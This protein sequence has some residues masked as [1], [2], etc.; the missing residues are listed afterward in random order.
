MDLHEYVSKQLMQNHYNLPVAFGI[1]VKKE[2]KS[3]QISENESDLIDEALDKIFSMGIMCVVKAQVYAGGRGEAGGVK[4][5]TKDRIKDAKEYAKKLLGSYLVTKQTDKNGQFVS[6]IY[7]E[8]AC[9]IYKEFYL[10][11]IV[12]REKNCISMVLSQ[13]GG[14]D[15]EYVCQKTPEKIHTLDIDPISGYSAFYA[16]I[17]CQK[18]GLNFKKYFKQLDYILMNFYKMFIEKDL[19]M[20]EINPLVIMKNSDGSEGDLR[21][22]DAKVSIDDNALWRQKDLLA[23]Y[24]KTQEKE[25]ETRAKESGLSYVKLDGNIGCMV[26][27]AGLA[28]ASMDIIK[29]HGGSPANFL[30]VGGGAS[31]EGVKTALNIIFKDDTVKCVLINIFGGIVRC[32]MIASAT[33]DAIKDLRDE[34]ANI[35]PIVIRLAG[36]NSK[37]GMQIISDSASTLDIKIYP[38]N[39]LDEA[40]KKSVTLL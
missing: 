35:L 13:E 40:A 7:F 28:M 25:L 4:L 14:M 37:E 24:D 18:L 31:K 21:I 16:K 10:S 8:L 17:V 30:D 27:G 29:V 22:L 20:L 6:A 38:V 11:Y 5:F 15:I 9:D 32:D 1:V 34:G 19:S 36:T 3:T 39:T 26:N 12:N 2:S 23:L 33:I